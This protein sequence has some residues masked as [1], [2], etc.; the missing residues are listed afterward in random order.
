MRHIGDFLVKLIALL[1]LLKFNH[2]DK[3]IMIY[4]YDKINSGR[5]LA[6]ARYG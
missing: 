5:A 3:V 1:L 2:S 6:V 4:L